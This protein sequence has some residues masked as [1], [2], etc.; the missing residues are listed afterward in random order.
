MLARISWYARTD[1]LATGAVDAVRHGVGLRVPN[2]IAVIG[3][4]DAPPAS[5]PNYRLT[6]YRQP[7]EEM[8]AGLIGILKGEIPQADLTRLTGS[9]IVRESA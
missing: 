4:D 5:N 2:D 7:I 9:L 3:F 1:A 8:A 6:T